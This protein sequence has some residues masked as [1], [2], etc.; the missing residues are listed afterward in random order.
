[1]AR[2]AAITSNSNPALFHP[3]DN[4]IPLGS[5]YLAVRAGPSEPSI[6]ACG[7]LAGFHAGNRNR[8][9]NF[10]VH[11]ETVA[12]SGHSLHKTRIIGRVS[13][14]LTKFVN[15]FIK[16]VVEIYESV[17]GPEVFFCSSS[18]AT[19]SPGCSTSIAR[20]GR[21]APEAGPATRACVIL[22]HGGPAQK[23]QSGV[24]F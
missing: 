3:R 24:V 14:R 13:Q 23:L 20:T 2:A 11:E 5:A 18:R 16:P 1:M 17:R 15:C 6:A 8:I 22:R 9:G 19:T 21:V 10:H 12:T 7:G 4:C